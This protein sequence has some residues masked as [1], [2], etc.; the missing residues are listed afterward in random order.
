MDYRS[1]EG[2]S[3]ELMEENRA[4][5]QKR[6]GPLKN[7]LSFVNAFRTLRLRP[8]PKTEVLFSNIRDSGWVI[9]NVPKG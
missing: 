9:Q 2:V 1:Q 4:V 5:S 8:T 7:C 6:Y 3:E